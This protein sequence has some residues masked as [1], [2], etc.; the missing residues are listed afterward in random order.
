[1]RRYP[2]LYGFGIFC[3]LLG[4]FVLAFSA[5]AQDTSSITGKVTGDGGAP[6]ENVQVVVY[7]SFDFTGMIFWNPIAQGTTNASGDYQVSALEGGTY[8]VG[9]R[10]PTNPRVYFEQYYNGATNIVS[11]TDVIVPVATVVPNI[12]VQLSSGAHIKGKVTGPANEGL[13]GIKITI[14]NGGFYTEGYTNNNGVYNIGGL[15]SGTYLV[16][17]RDDRENPQYAIE[18]YDNAADGDEPTPVTV[19]ANQIL[20]NI[21]AKLERLAVITGKVTDSNGDP[22]PDLKV[23][24]LASPTAPNLPWDES[25]YTHTDATGIYTLTSL[26]ADVYRIAFEDEQFKRY[27]TDNT[28]AI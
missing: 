24:A 18:R 16:T 17:F 11:A 28:F 9:F 6:V 10:P 2:R 8:R 14:G 3:L 15:D 27:S 21:N 20:A 23:V 7:Q 5:R 26:Y 22:V 13:P 12:N 25:R 4:T 1:M 19:A